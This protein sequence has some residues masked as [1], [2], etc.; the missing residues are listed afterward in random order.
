LLTKGRE[1][2]RSGGLGR[3]PEPPEAHHVSIETMSCRLIVGVMELLNL[4]N[5]RFESAW[6][7][8]HDLSSSPGTGGEGPFISSL[9]VAVTLPAEHTYYMSWSST[10]LPLSQPSRLNLHNTLFLLYNY[11]S[12]QRHYRQD[13][14]SLQQ[15]NSLASWPRNGRH[16]S[17][18]DY[19]IPR[20]KTF[21]AFIVVS[22]VVDL[23]RRPNGQPNTTRTSSSAT[24]TR[25]LLFRLHIPI[26]PRTIFRISEANL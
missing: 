10:P 2:G 22:N 15:I 4:S 3:S 21:N 9:T 6:F 24:I 17:S 7:G 26:L 19:Q 16:K 8:F 18:H 14:H 23:N 25:R 1:A 12:P 5:P 13:H 11:H 20:Y